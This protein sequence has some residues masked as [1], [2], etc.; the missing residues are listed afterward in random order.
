MTE[1]NG[2]NILVVDDS[3]TMRM[4]LK[5][6]IKH[7]LPGIS[8]TEAVDGVDAQ[9][10]VKEKSFDIVI[11]DIV[12][13][14]MGGFELVRWIKE[15]VSSELPVIMVTTHGEEES[16]S[17]GESLGVEDYLTKPVDW[18]QLKNVVSRLL[19]LE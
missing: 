9:E 8:V 12:M 15:S 3:S 5:M 1:H 17:M 19:Y 16:R 18:T 2:K 14:N 7:V 4:L 6:T 11:T 13:P 10:K